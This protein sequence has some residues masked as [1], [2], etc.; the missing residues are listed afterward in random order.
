MF[1]LPKRNIIR[2]VSGYDA[3]PS[4]WVPIPTTSKLHGGERVIGASLRTIEVIL[5]PYEAPFY[6]TKLKYVYPTASKLQDV[7]AAGDV[8]LPYQ[9]VSPSRHFLQTS[10]DG[11]RRDNAQN[12]SPNENRCCTSNIVLQRSISLVTFCSYFVKVYGA[13]YY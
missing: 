5:F 11:V 8:V 3:T 10:S 1:I 12:H 2:N 13:R 6:G 4:A 7:S 9:Y